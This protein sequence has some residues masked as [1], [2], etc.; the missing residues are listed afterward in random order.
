[1][2]SVGGGDEVVDEALS[3]FGDDFEQKLVLITAPASGDVAVFSVVGVNA[4]VP[5]ALIFS[6]PR[7]PQLFSR[8]VSHLKRPPELYA[9][10]G[11]RWHSR[12]WSPWRRSR[13]APCCALGRAWKPLQDGD[14]PR[15]ACRSL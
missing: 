9:P 14:P 5:Q 12:R 11:G 8:S 13:G 6:P 10:S 4:S 7:Y 2:V 1:M 3:V 15:P